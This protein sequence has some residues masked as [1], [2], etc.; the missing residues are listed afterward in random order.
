ML[1]GAMLAMTMLAVSPA[2]ANMEEGGD[3]TTLNVQECIA[4]FGDQSADQ[5][6]VESDGSVQ[7]LTQAQVQ[8]CQQLLGNV[9][10]GGDA[11]H[12]DDHHGTTAG[13]D[14]ATLNAQQCIAIF[15]DQDATQIQYDSDGSFQGLSQTQV[16]YCLQV[17]ENVTAGGQTVVEPGTGEVTHGVVEGE[18]HHGHGAVADADTG[19]AHTEGFALLPDTGGASLLILGAGAA[20]ISG[21]LLARKLAR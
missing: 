19:V 14:A 9:T 1:L 12:G 15:G 3:A 17:I 2:L 10:A 16:Q 4:I 7:G 18:V 6:Q 8:Y 13:G 11:H 5:Y 21:G 20:L